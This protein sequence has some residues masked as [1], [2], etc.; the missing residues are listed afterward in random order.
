MF[1]VSDYRN[2]ILSRQHVGSN[3]N[4]IVVVELL[5]SVVVLHI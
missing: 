3:V 1:S 2:I 5:S 4:G